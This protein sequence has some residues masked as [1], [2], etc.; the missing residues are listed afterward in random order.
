[1]WRL[2]TSLNVRHVGNTVSRALAGEFGTLDEIMRHDADSLAAT[3]EIGE[4]IAA[5][6]AAWFADPANRA[7]VEEFRTLG[8]NF[9]SEAEKT[10]KAVATGVLGGKSL[11]VTGTLNRFKR[12]EIEELIREHGGK[13]SSS[14]SKRTDYLVAGARAGS[15]LAKAEKA[16][17][18]VLSEE[19][20][21][22]LVGLPSEPE[23]DDAQATPG[24]ASEE[25]AGA[26][27]A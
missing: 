24:A 16:G 13:P 27:E 4:V 17:V 23:S 14:V 8:L 15:K 25:P 10:P 26:A 19:Q 6:L 7:T 2:L 20:F 22:A 21:A 5:S 9:G 3:Q 1:M 18:P 12:D 11:V